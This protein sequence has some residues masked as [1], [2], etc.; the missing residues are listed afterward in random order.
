MR[1]AS[2]LQH[3][4][5][6]HGPAA[7]CMHILEN[8]HAATGASASHEMRPLVLSLQICFKL[9]NMKELEVAPMVRSQQECRVRA[10]RHSFPLG[11]HPGPS[12]AFHSQLLCSPDK[13]HASHAMCPLPLQARQACGSQA[14]NV[15][16]SRPPTCKSQTQQSQRSVLLCHSCPLHGTT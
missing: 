2:A 3:E 10:A 7:V 12:E 14:A 11:P 5:V 6:L 16:G 8:D 15:I 4:P 13:L 1:R 9:V